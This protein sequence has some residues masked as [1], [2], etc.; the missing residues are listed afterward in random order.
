MTFFFNLRVQN[1]YNLFA[2]QRQKGVKEYCFVGKMKENDRFSL[3]F[4]LFLLLY[5]KYFLFLW[6]IL[7]L[8][9]P[10]LLA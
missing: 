5:K 8:R 2:S 6:Q 10:N 9:I 3:I 4:S 7:Y 1:Y